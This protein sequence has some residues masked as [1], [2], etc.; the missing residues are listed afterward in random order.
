MLTGTPWVVSIATPAP[1]RVEIE[2]MV[3]GRVAAVRIPAEACDE[4]AAA[5]GDDSDLN[6]FLGAGIEVSAVFR[7]R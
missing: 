1:D 3:P 6:Y 4:G 7:L 2:A 5:F